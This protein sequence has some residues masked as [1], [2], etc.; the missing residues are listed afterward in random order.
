VGPAIVEDP[1]STAVIL[2]GDEARMDE[3]GNLIVAVQQ[4]G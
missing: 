3:F 4:E 1:E 2:A